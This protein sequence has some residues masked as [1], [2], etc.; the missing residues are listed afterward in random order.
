MTFNFVQLFPKHAARLEVQ[1]TLIPRADEQRKINPSNQTS[2]YQPVE[3]LHVGAVTVP[4]VDYLY[5]SVLL[6]P[7]FPQDDIVHAT[8]WV[9]PRVHL[10]MSARKASNQHFG[11]IETFSLFP[12]NRRGSFF[13]LRMESTKQTIT[14][15]LIC[16]FTVV[17]II[18]T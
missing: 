5:S 7:E 3:I 1:H 12:R 15:G 9:C 16:G 18:I 10:F 4:V 14:K 8:Q 2:L 17:Y 6:N 13:M 11:E